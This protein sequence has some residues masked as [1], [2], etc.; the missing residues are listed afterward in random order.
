MQHHN[1]I[2]N[3]NCTEIKMLPKTKSNELEKFVLNIYEVLTVKIRF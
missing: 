1:V 2:L 3:K